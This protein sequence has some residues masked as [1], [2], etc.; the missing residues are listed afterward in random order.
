MFDSVDIRRYGAWINGVWKETNEYFPVIHKY[1]GHA[2]AEI[3][4]CQ[5]S[6]VTEAISSAYQTFKTNKLSPNQRYEILSRTSQLLKENKDD[7]ASIITQEV[8]KPIK[9]SRMEVDRAVQTFLLS[10]EEA[11]RLGGEGIPIGAQAGSEDRISF[12][13]RV[14]VGVI[15]AITPFNFP[16]NLTAHKIGP[17]IAGGNTVVLKPSELT[18]L[19]SIKLVELL[20]KAG[21]PDGF[22]NV[23]NGY[24]HEAGEALLHDP[25]IAMYTFT[26][27]A[28]VGQHIKSQTGIRKVTLELGS[29]SPNIIHEDANIDEA[30]DLCMSRGFSNAGQ[31]CISVQ[32]I[33]VHQS[34]Y[35]EF[36]NK[37]VTF[38][39]SLQVGD[40]EQEQTALGPMINEKE[41][42]RAEHWLHEAIE[43]GAKVEIGGKREGTLFYPTILTAVTPDMKVSCEELFAPVVTIIPYTDIN[44]AFSLANDSQF[45]L[46]VGLFTNNHSI[47]MDAMQELEFGGVIVN[48]VSTYRA[49]LMPYGGVKNSGVGKEGPRYSIEEMTEARVVVLRKQGG[50][51]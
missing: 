3:G 44:E 21:L 34:V 31:A 18:P 26:G 7:I 2:I 38:V 29:N 37:S 5:E 13:V 33:Y 10:S 28:K 36:V 41:A 50:H 47:I 22:I 23:V 39:K 49:D 14:P 42:S 4:R 16:L 8:G 51:R 48:D 46:H 30:V 43:A 11:K 20:K 24:G 27:S 17:A 25:R 12:T 40:P 35:S 15:A 9:E 32:R 1:K 19:S 45:G 6:D